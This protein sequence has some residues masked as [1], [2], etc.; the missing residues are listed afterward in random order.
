MALKTS[1]STHFD[2]YNEFVKF[3]QNVN[4][5]LTSLTNCVMIIIIIILFLLQLASKKHSNDVHNLSLRTTDAATVSP[6][7]SFI[8]RTSGAQSFNKDLTTVDL[9]NNA[10]ALSIE[11]AREVSY[12]VTC[13]NT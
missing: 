6:K 2:T 4:I 5:I 11:K 1:S 10:D 3:C 13:V 7:E 8:G 12:H 9:N